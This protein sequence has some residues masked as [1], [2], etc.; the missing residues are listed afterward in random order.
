MWLGEGNFDRADVLDEEF[1]VDTLNFEVSF[2]KIET[3]AGDV[4]IFPWA[5]GEAG[6]DE[7][8]CADIG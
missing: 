8:L 6:T 4:E 2:E 7:G 1:L 5:A 3:V